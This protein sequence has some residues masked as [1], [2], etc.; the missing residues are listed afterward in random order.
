MVDGFIVTAVSSH[1]YNKYYTKRV[2]TI[3]FYL[4]KLICHFL[5]H[6]SE[7]ETSQQRHQGH[8]CDEKA[9]SWCRWHYSCIGTL[10]KSK[11]WSYQCIDS[12]TL[13]MG[14]GSKWLSFWIQRIV[15]LTKF[16]SLLLHVQHINGNQVEFTV[17]LLQAVGCSGTAKL[18]K[19]QLVLCL[20][21]RLKD[22]IVS[23]PQK[24]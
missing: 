22:R 21:A 6:C 24:I 18:M 20:S 15:I 7:K 3:F 10:W 5:E 14:V 12:L 19:S 2:I 17:S 8:I 23:K 9:G 1:Y 4:C 16:A 11:S 13:S